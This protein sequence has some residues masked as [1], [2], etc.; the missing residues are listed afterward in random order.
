MIVAL[1]SV[2]FAE[3]MQTKITF[4]NGATSTPWVGTFHHEY[5]HQ[6]FGDNVSEA[7]FNL[8]FWKEGWAT[9]GEYL[10]TA[11]TAANT[12]GGLGT[13]AGDA[14][15]DISLNNRFNTNY[16]GGRQQLDQRS[17]EPDRRQ[18]VHDVSTYTRAGHDV[19]RAAPD[20]GRLGVAAEHRTAGSVS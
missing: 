7:A 6:W 15:F 11:R 17:V 10:N 1:P 16:A 5:M 3:E 13:P 18:P 4:G 20:P 9:V 14:A 2:G 12:A 8:T 19:P